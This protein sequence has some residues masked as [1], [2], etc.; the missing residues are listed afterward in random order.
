MSIAITDDHRALAAT[1]SDLLAK[2][3]AIGAARDLLEADTEERPALWSEMVSLGWVGIHLPEQYGGSGYGLEEL[4]VLVEETGRTVTPGPFVPTVIASAVLNAIADDD[5]KGRFLPGLADGS[6]CAAVALDGEVTLDSSGAASGSAGV[7]LGGGL[8]QLLVVAVGDD[9]A[10]VEVGDGVSV[11]VPPNLDP[12]RR[13]ARVTLDG[14]PATVIAGGA[15]VLTD[16]ARLILSAEAVGLAG[17]VMDH[18][19]RRLEEVRRAVDRDLLLLHALEHRGLGLG[20]GTVDLVTNHD[21]REHAAGA[22]LEVAS[23][24]VVDRHPGHVGGQQI[25]G[26]LDPADGAVDRAGQRLG[27]HRLADA[28]HVLDQEVS[29]A[30]QNHDG[31]PGHLGL[32]LD[33]LLDGALDP[34]GSRADL[35]QSLRIGPVDR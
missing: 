29:L 5:L 15:Q 9:L 10:V 23:L 3:N 1:A 7:V 11:E 32:A 17:A 35:G 4:V 6:V 8:A 31:K 30:E 27:Q 21:V 13:S 19:E 18:H 33:H 22:E 16:L 14:A 20:R 34:F 12:T 2:R 28:W 26:E 24:L 25:R